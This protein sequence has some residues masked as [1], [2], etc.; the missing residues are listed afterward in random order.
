MKIQTFSIVVG[1]KACD[2]HCPFCISKQTGYDELPTEP[3][4]NFR[5]LDKAIQLARMGETTTCLITGKGEPTLYPASI[6]AYLE[7]LHGQFPFIELQT[8]GLQIG[9]LAA[10]QEMSTL[11]EG[12][13]TYW[14]NRGLDTIALSV[15]G[16]DTEQNARIYNKN[17][18]DLATTVKYLHDLGFSVRLCVMLMHGGVDTPKELRKVIQWCLEHKVEQLTIRPIRRAHSQDNKDLDPEAVR[19]MNRFGLDGQSAAL[20]EMRDWVQQNGTLLLTM[21]H[22]ARVY[23]VGGQ[24]VCVSDCLTLSEVN[25]D[26]RTL[27]YYGNGRITYDWQYKGAV[28]LGGYVE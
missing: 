16:I 21:M 4:I 8:N 9:R 6:E 1:S 22:G 17:Y 24:N 7:Y 15:A 3:E 2:A 11:S 18:P 25:D 19:F 27:I 13:L 26:L 10:G 23:D 5:N 14:Y 12:L 20:R 28:L